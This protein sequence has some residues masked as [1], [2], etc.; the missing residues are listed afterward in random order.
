MNSVLEEIIRTGHVRSAAGELIPLH[1][2]VTPEV[3][4][5]LQGIVAE[6]GAT[7]SLEVGLAYGVSA[8]FI[9]DGLQR[10][11]QTRHFVIDPSQFKLSELNRA[12]GDPAGRGSW[13]GIG[14]ENLKRAGYQE[15]IEFLEQPSHLALPSL[16]ARGVKVD[17]AFIDGW[18]TFDQALLDFF[19]AD[20][21][22]R[23]G[24]VV[25]LDDTDFKSIRKVCRYVVTNRQYTVLRCLPP[26]PERRISQRAG[27]LFASVFGS[28]SR[29]GLVRGS[30]CMAFKKMAED[31][32]RWD[33]HQD[34]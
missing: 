27:D 21:L 28:D 12:G 10:S 30:R 17:F 33:F 6:I 25:V 32:R 5:F 24:G 13:E 20:R 34:F 15:I 7:V 1:S 29:L 31:Q 26:S 16:E 2:N 4:F 9:C 18:H 23:V 22:L 3:G 8:L 19:Y 11:A 14:L